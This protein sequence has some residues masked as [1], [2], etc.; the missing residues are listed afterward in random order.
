MNNILMQDGF[1]KLPS[2][3]HKATGH[4][5]ADINNLFAELPEFRT[6]IK[7]FSKCICNIPFSLTPPYLDT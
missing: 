2:K 7:I 1:L 4:S 6:S 5:I 3:I